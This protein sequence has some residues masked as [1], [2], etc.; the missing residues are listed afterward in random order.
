M[1]RIHIKPFLDMQDVLVQWSIIGRISR[2]ADRINTEKNRTKFAGDLRKLVAEMQMPEFDMCRMAAERFLEHIDDDKPLVQLLHDIEELRGRILDQIDSV[3][4]LALSMGEKE[5]FE[6]PEPIFGPNVPAKFSSAL[7]DIDEGAKCLATGRYT[8]CV[9]HLMRVM[10]IGVQHLGQKLKVK[11][12]PKEQS[13]HQILLH[14]N[15]ATE[16]L[17]IKTSKQKSR[18]ARFATCS[19]HLSNVR[20]AWRNEVMHPKA[21][22]TQ[23][24]AKEIF[25]HVK[26][27]M[28][29]LAALV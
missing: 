9:F 28:R 17:S 14:V 26:T 13:W 8:A 21:T 1:L 7:F 6:P 22:Y 4:F 29:D 12:N 25:G 24:E 20:I 15:K 23:E 11:I 16:A 10:E 19:A 3:Y 27:F 5:Y 18:K 2:H